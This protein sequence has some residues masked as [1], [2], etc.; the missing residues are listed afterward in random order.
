MMSTK[1]GL[2]CLTSIDFVMSIFFVC[3]RADPVFLIYNIYNIFICVFVFI[4]SIAKLRHDHG[5]SF[6]K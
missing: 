6:L 4:G 1:H 5:K 2:F 3:L